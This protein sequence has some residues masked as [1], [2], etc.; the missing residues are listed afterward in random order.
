MTSDAFVFSD[1]LEDWINSRT[2][3]REE[4][5]KRSKERYWKKKE[6]KVNSSPKVLS[7]FQALNNEL[8]PR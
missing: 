5:A 1:K 3:Q 8:R 6:S 4:K 7:R 2:Q